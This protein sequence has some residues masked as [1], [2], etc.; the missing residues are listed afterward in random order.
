MTNS[1]DFAI[2]ILTTTAVILLVGIVVVQ[3]RPDSAYAAGMTAAGG[4]YVLAVGRIQRT[5]EELLYVIDS[6]EEKLVVYKCDGAKRQVQITD[7][8][9]LKRL[10]EGSD[11]PKTTQP[12]RGRGQPPPQRGRPRP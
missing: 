2:G 7:T 6:V 11:A 9:D 5:P 1:K 12:Q 4:D 8:V 10:R 3:T